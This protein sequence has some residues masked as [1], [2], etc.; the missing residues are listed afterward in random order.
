MD[1]KS[2]RARDRVIC[3]AGFYFQIINFYLITSPKSIK[4]TLYWG[5]PIVFFE[6]WPFFIFNYLIFYLSSLPS[7]KAAPDPYWDE[8]LRSIIH[9]IVYLILYL[10]F[11]RALNFQ[12]TSKA[13]LWP[14]VLT[15]FYAFSDEIH[16]SFVPTRTFQWK[17]LFFNFS[18][19]LLGGLG[20]WKLSRKTPPRLR[21]L[22]T[23]LG[24]I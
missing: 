1:Y 2:I 8:A 19:A 4:S 7:L 22:A 12:K 5:I 24:V 15:I 17:D 21:S 18:G 16:Q 3:M 20:L 14:L 6:S 9:V 11:F 10:L 13:F 23:E